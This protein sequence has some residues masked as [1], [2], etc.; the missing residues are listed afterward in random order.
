MMVLVR[1]VDRGTRHQY[2]LKIR[3]VEAILSVSFT[4]SVVVVFAVATRVSMRGGLKH[5]RP[6]NVIP[7]DSGMYG[8][9][10]GWM[11]LDYACSYCGVACLFDVAVDMS[12][13]TWSGS[14]GYPTALFYA[15]TL[16]RDRSKCCVSLYGLRVNKW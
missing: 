4:T 8:S 7:S 10:T 15:R 6:F 3:F 16:R 1:L 13:I 9:D 5:A 12:A 2:L 14:L 11:A